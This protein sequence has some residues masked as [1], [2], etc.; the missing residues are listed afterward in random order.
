[1]TENAG[2]VRAVGSRTSASV[3]DLR[4]YLALERNSDR[5][6]IPVND[7]RQLVNK[8]RAEKL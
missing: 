7:F 6:A 1:M 2:T 5:R 4:R 3:N 8:A